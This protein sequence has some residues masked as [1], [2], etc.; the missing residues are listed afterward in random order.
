[1]RTLHLCVICASFAATTLL[2]AQ[3]E[4]SQEEIASHL[5]TWV[6]P[7]YP[8]IAEAAHLQGD[9]I[10]KV[11]LG[12]DG[13]VRSAKPISGPAMLRLVTADALKQ[14]RYQPFRRG[15]AET[16]VT[17]NVL[18]SF[19]LGDKPAVHT[20]HEATANGSWTTSITLSP[21]DNRGEPDEEIANRFDAAWK[22]CSAGVIA[23]KT[24]M[25]VADAC[26][27]AAAIADEFS[28]DRRYIQRRAAYVYAATAFAN[29]RDLETALTYAEKAVVVVQSGHDGDSGAEAA[30]SVRGQL[31]AFSG[32]ME[33]GDQD[34]TL[35]EDYARK[36]GASV[37]LKRDLQFHAE[38]LNRM[39]RPKDAQ[40]KLEEAAKL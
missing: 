33:G 14:W 35:A 24:S 23:H 19:T 8:A 28:A 30:Y 7:V 5:M 36:A 1:M 18:V 34:M 22:T 6:A 29:V 11:E 27:Q 2:H 31:R 12:P 10:L 13:L 4:L 20:P 32:D 26:K 40:A 3:Q 39:N 17:G 25:D 16:A 37:V 9:V 15:N 38:L 21:P